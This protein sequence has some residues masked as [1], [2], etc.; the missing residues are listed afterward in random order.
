GYCD[1]NSFLVGVSQRTYHFRVAGF[2]RLCKM[3]SQYSAYILPKLARQGQRLV[4][5]RRGHIQVV[6][7]LDGVLRVKKELDVPADPRQVVHGQI[8]IAIHEDLDD[9]RTPISPDLNIDQKNGRPG[10]HLF[11]HLAN[12]PVERR[13][14]FVYRM[15]DPLT[16][17]RSALSRNAPG[18]ACSGRAQ[19]TYANEKKEALN[20]APFPRSNH[21]R[22]EAPKAN[23]APRRS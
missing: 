7:A 12:S 2:I 10:D 11:D 17:S 18:P 21:R 6:L 19:R 20:R 4:E 22:P 5:A 1:L 13:S 14:R 3:N 9:P 23:S 15:S 8:I 16:H